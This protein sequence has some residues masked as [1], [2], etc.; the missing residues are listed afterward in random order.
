MLEVGLA[1]ETHLPACFAVRERVFVEEQAVPP[2]LEVDG[3]DPACLHWFGALDGEVIAT[4][5]ARWIE[6]GVAKVERVAVLRSFRGRGHGHRLMNDVESEL[7]A[8]G[9]RFAVLASQRSAEPF[10]AAH[11]YEAEGEPFMEAGIEHVFMR[12][13]LSAPSS[14]RAEPAKTG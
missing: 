4:A 8:R 3:K 9:A 2:E 12:K 10:Y 7:A 14:G 1:D 5:R 13:P 11:G 6:P